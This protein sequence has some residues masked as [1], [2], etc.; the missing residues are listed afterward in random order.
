MSVVFKLFEKMDS[1]RWHLCCLLFFVVSCKSP[2]AYNSYADAEKDSVKTEQIAQRVFRQLDSLTTIIR[3]GDLITR[4]GNDNTSEILRQFNQTD[5]TYSHCGIASFENDSLFVYH[6]LGGDFNPDQKIRRDPFILFCDPYSNR[7]IG[8]FRYKLA[9]P[10][11]AL[12]LS[13]VQSFYKNGL[14]FDLEFNLKT[15][16]RMYCAEFIYKA[17]L[18]A[19]KNKLAFHISHI[20]DFEFISVD[21]LFLQPLCVP[22]KRIFYK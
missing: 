11:K 9:A 7:G 2:P 12:L 16:D 6:A 15:D 20:K 14:M 18:L 1:K 3:N 13:T 21:D 17:L 8:I 19:S 5:P 22:V 4:T 10:E